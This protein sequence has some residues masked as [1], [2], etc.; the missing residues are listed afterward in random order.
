MIDLSNIL[1]KN[2]RKAIVNGILTPFSWLYGAGVWLRNTAF[3]IGILKQEQFDVPV[4]SVGNITVGG[5][6]K[7]PH[8][9]YIV[10][11]L[12]RKYNIAVLSRGYKRATRGFI[13]ASDNISVT[14]LGDEP[15][16]I[17]HKFNGLITLAVCESR[18]KGI[19]ELLRINPDINLILLDDAFQHRYVKPK[20]NIV[21]VDFSRPPFNDKLMPLGNLREPA[22]HIV[23]ADVVVVT[24]CPND[25]KPVQIRMMKEN[26]ELFPATQLFFSNIKYAQ[27]VPVFPI[28]DPELTTLN[29]LEQDDLILGLTGIA[30]HRPFHRYLKQFGTRLKLI[31]Y[32]DHHNYTRD[33]FR[34]IFK[35]FEG[36]EG[37]RKFIVTTE[38]D[39]VRI[40]NNPY[41]PPEM[42]KYIYYVPIR[43]GFL[44]YE[45]REFIPELEKKIIE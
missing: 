36:L 7:T 17:F 2:Q 20:V 35:V 45:D 33:D 41:Y 24:K 15:Y 13:L 1:N 4:V 14:D 27:P 40:L 6:G 3:E 19:K 29:W 25:I 9:E 31:H 18:R 12:C 21:L 22:D 43:V 30:N 23:R 42:R 32:D 16:Q 26:L 10:E 11:H 37:R 44:N 28:R 39:A 5:T 8:V 38:K 34:Y